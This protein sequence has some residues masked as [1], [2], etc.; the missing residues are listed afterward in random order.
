VN[1]TISLIG[2]MQSQTVRKLI[3]SSSA[4][5]YGVSH[6]L[7]CDEEHPLAPIN[8]YGKS[9][10]Q[11]EQIMQD[12]AKSDPL[13]SIVALRYF[14]PVGA[15]ES[16][17]IGEVPNG[18]PNNLMP[19]ICQVASGILPYL[20]VFGDDY[21]TKDGTGERDYIHVMDLAE[22]HAAAIDWLAKNTGF[23][24]INLGTGMPYSV[25]D[26]ISAFEQAADCV[27]PKQVK[28]RREGDLPIYY[29][30]AEKAK[31]ILGWKAKRDLQMMCDSSWNFQSNFQ[32]S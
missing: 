17:L 4:T 15:H 29:A 10:L 30:K 2:A 20:N 19:Y 23:E 18:I 27:I 12:L 32:K 1:G 7:P 22:G 14:N 25:Y 13:W 6:Y 8:P 9:K 16:G 31:A 24:A 26:L 21:D 11:A 3:F 5:V 28:G